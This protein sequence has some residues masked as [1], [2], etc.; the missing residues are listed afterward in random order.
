M[1][2]IIMALLLCHY[3]S[4]FKDSKNTLPSERQIEVRIAG[5]H[6]MIQTTLFV[7]TTGI[8]ALYMSRLEHWTYMQG[9]YFSVVSF[10][11]IGFGDFTPTKTAT[12]VVLFPFLLVG[13]V[14]LACLIGML[15]HYFSQ[16]VSM[17]HA[18][19]R[20]RAAKL[21]QEEEDKLSKEPN[22]ERE[23][24]FLAELYRSTNQHEAVKSLVV[25][26]VGF[27]TFWFIGALVFSRV[28]V[29]I[30][31]FIF[32]AANKVK[33]GLDIWPRSLFL[34]RL[35]PCSWLWRFRSHNTGRPRFVHLFCFS[36]G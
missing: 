13:I 34:L 25:A 5:R 3:I 30:Y 10:L 1:T 35:L 21:R 23:L 28:E 24:Q 29:R 17:Q 26:S 36:R 7:C 27:L 6:F 14:Q 2:A 18:N 12:Q 22:L 16:R 15:V 11:T 20:R 33:I 4:R 31:S 8:L 19:R 32:E 9:I